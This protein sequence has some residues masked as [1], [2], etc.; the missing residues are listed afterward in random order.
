[1]SKGL[2]FRLEDYLALVDWTRT[3]PE[4]NRGTTVLS[5]PAILEN[6]GFE[7]RHW[8]YLTSH[9]E[10]R[11]KNLVG[12]VNR[13]KAACTILNKHWCHGMA[14]SRQYFPS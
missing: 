11:L 4:D 1:M 9:F 5:A 7:P 2:P 13:L 8:L 14:V 6:L 3:Q 12:S 10:H